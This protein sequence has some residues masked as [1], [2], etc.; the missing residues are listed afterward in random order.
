[1]CSTQL[2]QMQGMFPL[3]YCAK[4]GNMEGVSILIEHGANIHNTGRRVRGTDSRAPGCICR[5]HD[6]AHSTRAVVYPLSPGCSQGQTALTF[7]ADSGHVNIMRE[8]LSR[9]LSPHEEHGGVRTVASWP[10]SDSH[11][12]SAAPVCCFSFTNVWLVTPSV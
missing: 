5:A 12:A 8:L 7:A 10:E 4:L 1:M 3:A 2:P 6:T 9:G 11:L